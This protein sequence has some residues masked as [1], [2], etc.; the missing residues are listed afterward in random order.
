[1]KSHN[2][3]AYIPTLIFFKGAN[4]ANKV[5]SGRS[6]EQK[7]TDFVYS[8][9]EEILEID[10]LSLNEAVKNILEKIVENGAA[11][12]NLAYRD[13]VLLINVTYSTSKN[14]RALENASKDHIYELVLD[15]PFY[16]NVTNA[17]FQKDLLTALHSY[18]L[19]FGLL[20]GGEDWQS[21]GRPIKVNMNYT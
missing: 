7:S 16:V 17:R 9:S 6:D 3:A 14:R 20:S 21:T 18:A 1:M 15:V 12:G 2:F 10:E 4:G 11:T 5:T 19:K 13:D 8:P